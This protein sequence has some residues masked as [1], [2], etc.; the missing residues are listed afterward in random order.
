MDINCASCGEPWDTY[1]IRHDAIWDTSIGDNEAEVKKWKAL[2]G[3]SDRLA[4]RYRQAFKEAGYEFGSSLFTIRKCPSCPKDAKPNPSTVAVQNALAEMMP[5]DLDGQA[6]MMD[7]FKF[8]GM[9]K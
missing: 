2:P 3:N 4:P 8:L 6:A 7:D 9:H 1:H 5:D